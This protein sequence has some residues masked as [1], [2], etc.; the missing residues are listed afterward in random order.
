MHIKYERPYLK[1]YIYTNSYNLYMKKTLIFT[2]KHY[3]I[4]YCHI[5]SYNIYKFSPS[6]LD[7]KYYM[8]FCDDWCLN[9]SDKNGINSTRI[10]YNVYMALVFN[11][12]RDMVC[13]QCSYTKVLNNTCFLI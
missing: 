2:L 10:R 11:T 13:K 9:A 12:Y 8:C 6:Y 1:Y 3:T 5:Y 7:I 4:C